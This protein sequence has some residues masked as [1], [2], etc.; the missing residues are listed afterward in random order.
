MSVIDLRG[1]TVAGRF[2]L[3]ATSARA[4]W[5]VVLVGFALFFA[6]PVLWLL[7]A[8]TKTDA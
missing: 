8:P 7:L 4:V 1:A 3:R 2:G 6:V 5:G